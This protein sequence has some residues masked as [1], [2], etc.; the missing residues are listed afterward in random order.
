MSADYAS[1][2]SRYEFHQPGYMGTLPDFILQTLDRILQGYAASVQ[3]FV[4]PFQLT[5]IVFGKIPAPKSAIAN[6]VW[7]GAIP[8]SDDKRRN[9][10]QTHGP[11]S[12][13]TVLSN[14]AILVYQ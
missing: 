11:Y 6:N 9:I 3:Y 7:G 14:P 4:S 8:R 13:N 5:D 12:R 1:L 2:R 10:L